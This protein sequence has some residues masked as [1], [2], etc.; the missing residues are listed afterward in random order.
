MDRTNNIEIL[1]AKYNAW[2]PNYKHKKEIR[3]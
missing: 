2:Y 1:A 3:N